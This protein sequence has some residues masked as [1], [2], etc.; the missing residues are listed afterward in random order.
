[1][2]RRGLVVK[3][4]PACTRL[5][6]VLLTTCVLAACGQAGPPIEE[7]APD[8]R[9][10]DRTPVVLVPGV[11]REVGSELR[12]GRYMP[13]SV[14]ALRTDAEALARLGDPRFPAGGGTP[15]ALSADLDRALRHT[16]VR[17]L[18]GLI[19]RLIREEGYLRGD[20]E[21]PLDKNYPENPEAARSDR[22]RPA[23]LF[24]VYYDWRRDIA[25]SACFLANRVARIRARTGASRVLVVGH[26]LGGVVARYYARYGGRDVMAG[27]EC[28]LATD[29]PASVINAPGARGM[30][31]L[32][33]LG[34]P[35]QGSVQAFRALLQDFNLWGVFSV[36]LRSAVFTMPLAWQLLPFAGSDGGVSLLA[37]NNGI[38]RV[39]LF[40]PQVWITRGCV[41]GDPAD[42]E[43]RQ[44]LGAMLRRARVLHQRLQ[45]P[46][47]AEEA[48]TRLA[49]GSTCL[50]TPALAMA[51]DGGVAFLSRFQG[52][53]PMFGRVT[54]PGDGIV[55]LDSALGLPT[56]ATLA[57]MTVCTGHS[58][59]ANDPS[60]TDRIAQLVQR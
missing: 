9:L 4:R 53:H 34:A 57:T 40:D 31:G 11:S 38:E 3:H 52:D 46:S 49:L 58:A 32:V 5:L 19:N 30:D 28:P 35:H 33:T 8:V 16:E 48:V 56:S 60:V 17:G 2:K 14:L 36:G 22:T 25:E 51:T 6:P 59:Y 21:H 10:V 26:S 37:G 44:F 43:R 45:E 20:P 39:A 1:M 42:P 54:V 55:S 24:V 50:P 27:R 47:P 41:V 7:A 15:L 29:A 12:G 18:Q 23:S 13:F